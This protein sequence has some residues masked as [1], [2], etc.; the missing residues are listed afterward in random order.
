MRV[1]TGDE[2]GSTMRE[3]VTV[4]S[5]GE[6]LPGDLCVPD[7][8][9]HDRFAAIVLCHATGARRPADFQ[10]ARWLCDRGY[11][12]LTFDWRGCVGAPSPRAV[13]PDRIAEDLCAGVTYLQ[14]RPDI[15][16]TRIGVL[17]RGLG[18]GFAVLAAASD[19]RIAAT[20][21]FSGFGDFSRR[22]A[23]H[24][25]VEVWEQIRALIAADEHSTVDAAVLLGVPAPISAGGPEL[26]RSP[27]SFAFTAE[28][29]QALFGCRPEEVVRDV[30][31]RPLLVIHAT[32]DAMFPRSEAVS[33][34]AK[35]RAG[36][37]LVFVD[38]T[39]H[40]E[41]YPGRNDS[42]YNHTMNCCEDFLR[43]HLI[44]QTTIDPA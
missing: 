21:C 29:V 19:T 44:R 16:P 14:S 30:A 3:T 36:A 8:G 31:P 32:G 34:Y 1:R 40:M 7:G 41:M 26:P 39:D 24:L 18:G 17:G 27:N 12:V 22:T 42:V 35:A 37:E 10:M 25:G 28:S 15:D 11:A 13:L 43:R 23:L 4:P 33:I 6:L 9:T 2:V 20:V 38:A 5:A